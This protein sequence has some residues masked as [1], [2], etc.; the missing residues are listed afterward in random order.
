VALGNLIAAKQQQVVMV[1]SS[2]IKAPEGIQVFLGTQVWHT[3]ECNLMTMPELAEKQ[4]S[5]K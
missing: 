4:G 3:A 5:N 2:T 1:A